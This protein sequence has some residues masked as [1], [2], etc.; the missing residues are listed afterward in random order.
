MSP[1]DR[2]I[3]STLSTVHAR[4]AEGDDQAARFDPLVSPFAA[5][6]DDDPKS[7]AKLVELIPER[8]KIMLL[9]RGEIAL[10]VGVRV[11]TT[12]EG[13]QMVAHNARFAV[14]EAFNP[15]RLGSSDAA[16][17]MAL[18]LLTKP[19]PFLPRTHELGEFW[20][21][22][23]D[24]RLVAMAGERMK[25]PGL[26]EVSGVCTHPDFRGRGWARHLS[27]LVARNIAARG[28]TPYLHAYA[29][30]QAAI[31]L[32]ESLGFRHRCTVAVA[33]LAGS[34]PPKGN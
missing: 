17:M 7:I 25:Q 5:T 27:S 21:I 1:L 32:Y 6:V 19:G 29:S 13:V 14:P 31:A 15:Q 11:L 9:Q 33:V 30:N 8:G 18:A 22:R 16:D 23:V 3:W 4:F 24:G 34:S 12:G 20:G 10:P 26:T 28:E 2:P